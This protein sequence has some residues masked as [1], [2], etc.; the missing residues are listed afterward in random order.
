MNNIA[1]N[2]LGENTWLACTNLLIANC[3]LPICIGY[4]CYFR[5]ALLITILC[6]SLV[7]S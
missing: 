6:T 4:N 1:L 3:L 2:Q 5:M 7:P